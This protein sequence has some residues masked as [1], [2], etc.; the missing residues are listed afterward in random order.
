[1]DWPKMQVSK[2]SSH[3][4]RS[5]LPYACN[6]T[7]WVVVIVQVTQFVYSGTVRANPRGKHHIENNTINAFDMVWEHRP[8]YTVAFSASN[9][10]S[11]AWP[12]LR[13]CKSG[14]SW[15]RGIVSLESRM[16]QGLPPH[17]QARERCDDAFCIVSKFSMT[18]VRLGTYDDGTLVV[19]WFVSDG[20]R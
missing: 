7:L 11:M 12:A 3:S 2:P 19:V 15:H 9:H 14:G 10:L 16:C 4:L 18:P 13:A 20:Q 1:M 8:S 5:V 6:V 17:V